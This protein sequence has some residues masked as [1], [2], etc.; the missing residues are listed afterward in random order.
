MLRPEYAYR[1]AMT[2]LLP[3]YMQASITAVS[4][5]SVPL[6]VKNDLHNLPGASRLNRSATFVWFSVKYSVDV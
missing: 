6:L 5:A 2:S 4:T 1:S 3:V